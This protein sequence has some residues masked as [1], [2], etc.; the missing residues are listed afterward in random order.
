MKK[1]KESKITKNNKLL[2][3][4]KCKHYYG[5]IKTIKKQIIVKFLTLQLM[6]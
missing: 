1:I 6:N 3:K 4:N 5:K 2:I